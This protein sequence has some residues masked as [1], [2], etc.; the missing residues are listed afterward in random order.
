MSLL[1]CSNVFERSLHSPSRHFSAA[2][3]YRGQSDWVELFPELLF[4]ETQ[5][6]YQFHPDRWG[7]IFIFLPWSLRSM[8]GTP[9][10]RPILKSFGSEY[11]LVKISFCKRGC[12]K[13]GPF[14]APRKVNFL[15]CKV[16]GFDKEKNILKFQ[17]E[18]RSSFRVTGCQSKSIF[19]PKRKGSK[20]ETPHYFEINHYK[21]SFKYIFIV[22]NVC[23]FY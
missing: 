13:T 7:I 1:V 14:F 9:S 15:W 3:V 21:T 5:P 19:W 2:I 20:Y 4:Q 12:G 23:L 11:F 16:V 18:H 17:D 22:F 8:R 6:S 10:S